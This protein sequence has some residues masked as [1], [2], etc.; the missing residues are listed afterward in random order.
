MKK[1]NTM[2]CS[3]SLKDVMLKIHNEYILSF[4]NHYSSA[5]S[6][7]LLIKDHIWCQI[8]CLLWRLHSERLI[9]FSNRQE[10]IRRNWKLSKLM[11][12]Q[13]CSDFGCCMLEL[14]FIKLTTSSFMQKGLE[15]MFLTI[16][17]NIK[18][19]TL[20]P[21]PIFCLPLI[22]LAFGAILL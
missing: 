10:F 3:Q 15:D 5:F 11:N 6:N 2:I 7:F 1:L 13:K 12:M 21:L 20:I 19:I 9:N 16:W 4:S 8:F 18:Y 17:V 22:F 14:C